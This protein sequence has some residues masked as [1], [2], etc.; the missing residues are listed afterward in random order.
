MLVPA[1]AGWIS[2]GSPR[3]VD[4]GGNR[5]GGWGPGMGARP[6]PTRVTT[7]ETPVPG[8]GQCVV[9]F[10]CGAGTCEY[11]NRAKTD[12]SSLLVSVLGV[13]NRC[14]GIQP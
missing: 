7:H 13:R 9:M 4:R 10:R 5:L 6:L 8:A 11:Q 14:T 12:R 1:P 2:S 3:A